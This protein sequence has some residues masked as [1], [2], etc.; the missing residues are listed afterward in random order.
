MDKLWVKLL[1]IAIIV[2]LAW[3]ATVSWAAFSGPPE[4][5]PLN[6]TPSRLKRGFSAEAT[7][8]A[9]ERNAQLDY[10]IAD[11]T[12]DARERRFR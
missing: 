4:Q 8:R 5:T 6:S 3:T 2:S 7:R 1:V 12:R 9:L 10:L 11:A